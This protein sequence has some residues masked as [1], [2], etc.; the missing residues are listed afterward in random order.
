MSRVQ[1]PFL[2]LPLEVKKAER[3]QVVQTC[4]AQWHRRGWEAGSWGQSC[5]IL[6]VTQSLY[7]G[8]VTP[9]LAVQ[10][11]VYLPCTCHTGGFH[12][13]FKSNAFLRP[14]HFCKKSLVGVW[15]PQSCTLTPA[16][17]PWPFATSALWNLIH[18]IEICGVGFS[19]NRGN[20]DSRNMNAPNPF[21]HSAS[22]PI[23]KDH[24]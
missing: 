1:L 11:P 19:E 15:L 4:S 5:W 17:S 24:F 13:G 16:S 22:V 20:Q 7:F 21:P 3:E 14:R 23:Q 12:F 2:P 18:K 8:G 9:A 6:L 10:L